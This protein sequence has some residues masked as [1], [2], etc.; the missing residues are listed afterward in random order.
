MFMKNNKAFT[1]V[2]LIVVITILAILWTVAFLSLQEY[3]TLARN[4][5]RIDW[6][7]KIASAVEIKKQWWINIL[8]F[9]NTG[10]E[11][12]SAEI[13]WES[14]IVWSDYKAG[15]INTSA[16]EL[17]NNDFTDPS[18]DQL[19]MIG[20]TT[21][22]WGEYQVVATLEQNWKNEAQISWTYRARITE[23]LNWN[24]SL[25]N[26][27]FILSDLGD[28]NKLLEWDIIT[29][30]GIPSNTRIV[31]ISDNGMTLKLSNNLTSSATNL[32]LSSD[33]SNGLIVSIDWTTPVTQSSNNVAYE[34]LR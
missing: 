30:A 32:Q 6:V 10:N 9:V 34:V 22:K 21:K 18:N 11:L 12:S 19:F 5:V 29:W 7:S 23:L 33:E 4:S 1:L 13:G 17:K 25:W 2:E 27:T 28:I 15:T 20:A 24:W 14:A 16:M 3:T 26:N 8:S 31:W